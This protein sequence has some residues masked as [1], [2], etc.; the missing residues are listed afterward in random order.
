MSSFNPP[1][2]DIIAEFSN[3][4]IS[5]IK[6]L[7]QK[8]EVLVSEYNKLKESYDSL[9][10]R[11][12]EIKAVYAESENE[13]T[14]LTE[15]LINHNIES[16]KQVYDYLNNAF[17]SLNIINKQDIKSDIKQDIKSDIK[18]DIKSD[19]KPDIKPD[20]KQESGPELIQKC[21]PTKSSKKCVQIKSRGE[22]SDDSDSD[23]YNK[24][25]EKFGGFNHTVKSA[26]KRPK[27][28]YTEKL[29][30]PFTFGMPITPAD[31]PMNSEVFSN[32]RMLRSFFEMT[33][34][35]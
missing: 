29:P 1:T 8:N 10:D 22:S 35:K 33:G 17:N 16:N 9:N 31:K 7:Q 28:E 26:I 12:N 25:F 20:Y 2:M 3:K 27:S 21:G 34:K 24:P 19:I 6:E 23:N 18:Q 30:T 14:Q 15:K 11:H 13:N 4:F 5:Q 32:E